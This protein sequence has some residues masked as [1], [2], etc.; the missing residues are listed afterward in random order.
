MKTLLALLIAVTLVGC[1]TTVPVTRKFPEAPKTLIEKC[2]ELKKLA[3]DAKLSDVARTV[4]G[5]YTQ[6]QHCSNKSDAWV[7]WYNSQKKIFEEV[8]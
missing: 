3:Q 5:N 2:P 6:Y 8:K 4:V 1:S 7:E